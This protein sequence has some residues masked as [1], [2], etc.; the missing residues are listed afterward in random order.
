MLI[1]PAPKS[2]PEQTELSVVP[3]LYYPVVH[4]LILR[5]FFLIP[6]FILDSVF[7]HWLRFRTGRCPAA[8]PSSRPSFASHHRLWYSLSPARNCSKSPAAY[9]GEGV[10]LHAPAMDKQ[11][12]RRVL[13]NACPIGSMKLPG[14]ERR[15]TKQCLDVASLAER[16]TGTWH[17]SLALELREEEQPVQVEGVMFANPICRSF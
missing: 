13:R 14:C 1:Q 9:F 12:G 10:L 17:P 5:I 7:Y 16:S 11:V 4:Q 6:P 15:R 8:L 3:S 2:L